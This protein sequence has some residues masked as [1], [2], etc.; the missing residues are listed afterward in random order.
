MAQAYATHGC[1]LQSSSNLLDAI[2]DGLT[3]MNSS[4]YNSS[5]SQVGNWWDWQIGTPLA[6]NDVMCWCIHR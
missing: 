1:S 5:A 2:T 4:I 6:L 3:W